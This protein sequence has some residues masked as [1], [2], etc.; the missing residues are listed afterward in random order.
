MH[1]KLFA[2]ILSL[3]LIFSLAACSSGNKAKDAGN[4][5]PYGSGKITKAPVADESKPAEEP[6][7]EALDAVNEQKNDEKEQVKEQADEKKQEE[8]DGMT[9]AEKQ[10]AVDMQMLEKSIL[11]NPSF[12]EEGQLQWTARGGEKLQLTDAEAYSGKYSL[13]T[14]E[15]TTTWQGPSINLTNLLQKGKRYFFSVK[16]KY[17]DGP[18][19]NSFNLQFETHIAGNVSYPTI[20]RAS[21]KKNVWTTIEG[22]YVIPD[23]ENLTEYKLYVELSWKPDNEL[24]PDDAIDFYIDHVVIY[25]VAPLTYQK[26]IVPLKEAFAD[27]FPIGAATSTHFLNEKEIFAEF[28]SYHYGVLV[29]GNAMKPASLQP[30]EG[31]FYWQEADQFVQFAQDHGMLLRGHT[32]LWHSQVPDWFFTDPKDSSKPATREQLLKRMETHI[33]TVVGRYKGK[34]YSW[35]VVNEVI[36]DSNGLRGTSENSKWKEIIGD[37][38]GDGFDSDYIE[39]AFKYAHEADPDA[40]LIINDYGLESTGR[41]RTDMY[42]LIKRMLEKGI[43]VDGVGL[44]MHISIYSPS[45]KEIE[46]CIELFASLKEYNPDFTVE[47]T[48]M[49]MSVYSWMQQ[50]KEITNELLERQAGR[51]K[52]IFDV[53]KEQA[54]KGNLS[55]VVFWG[56]GDNDSWLDD[57]P[58]QG[59]GDAALL[60]DRKLQAKPA[61]YAITKKD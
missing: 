53:F 34:V 7:T 46:E 40:K 29:A 49:D 12:E 50:K 38:D 28:L 54:K 55:M 20:A 60:F 19:S 39:L 25:E 58:I 21:V 33:K 17:T 45:A 15:R 18:A 47:V 56:M 16:V 32:L 11:P 30:R 13:L 27:Y 3:L 42:N 10:A 59:R 22:E 31:Q 51:Y 24:T 5:E 44:Q 36:S 14:S 9:A 61:Y 23:D 35:D 2:V 57:F 1:S 43:P 48:E 37:V 52:E 6:K 4:Q 26:D 41:K 8:G